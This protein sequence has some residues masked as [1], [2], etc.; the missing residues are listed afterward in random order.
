MTWDFGEV[1]FFSESVGSWTSLVLCVP[2][3][4][5]SDAPDRPC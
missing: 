3:N 4:Y 2:S 1:N 5:L